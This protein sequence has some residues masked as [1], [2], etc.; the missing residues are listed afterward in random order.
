MGKEIREVTSPEL[1]AAS[2]RFN[3][4]LDRPSGNTKMNKLTMYLI[5]YWRGKLYKSVPKEDGIKFSKVRL[6]ST[7]AVLAEPQEGSTSKDIIVYIYI[8]T[9]IF[10]IFDIICNKIT[11]FVR[12]FDWGRNFAFAQ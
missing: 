4:A 11:V 5:R 3:S 9:D 12:Q 1:K 7:N 6:G 2:Q 8:V 10:I